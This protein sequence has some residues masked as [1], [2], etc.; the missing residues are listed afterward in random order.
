MHFV[1]TYNDK[2]TKIINFASFTKL[3]I[4]SFPK[5]YQHDQ[6]KKFSFLI[7][8]MLKA[9]E[10]VKKQGKELHLLYFKIEL[11]ISV[12]EDDIV[13][14]SDIQTVFH[15]DVIFIVTFCTIVAAHI[16]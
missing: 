1:S 13:Q 9:Q 4:S 14:F 5:Q 11:S 2:V 8:P 10:K 7:A 12:S 6:Q 15:Y 3:P 16:I